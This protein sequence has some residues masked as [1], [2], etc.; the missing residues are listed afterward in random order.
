MYMIAIQGIM[1]FKPQILVY[2][3]VLTLRDTT[4]QTLT[5]QPSVQGGVVTYQD[6]P[7]VYIDVL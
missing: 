5:L 7:L 2:I 6:S 4:V 1:S 3:A